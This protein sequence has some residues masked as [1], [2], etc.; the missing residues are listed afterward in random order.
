[1]AYKIKQC[2]LKSPGTETSLF[3]GLFRYRKVTWT[4]NSYFLGT[5]TTNSEF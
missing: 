2:F 4:F 1:M 3:N 5:Y